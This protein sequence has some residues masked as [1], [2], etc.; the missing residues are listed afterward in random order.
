MNILEQFV[1]AV[2]NRGDLAHLVLFAWAIAASA[3]LAMTLRDLLAANRRFDEFV[4]ELSVFNRRQKGRVSDDI[5]KRAS[6]A[7]PKSRPET[8][9][10]P[11][12]QGRR[13][14]SRNAHLPRLRAPARKSRLCSRPGPRGKDRPTAH[15]AAVPRE[16][17]LLSEPLTAN[18]ETGVFEGYASLFGIPDLGKGRGCSGSFL[19]RLLRKRGT[20]PT[21]GCSGSMTRAIR[22][23]C[24]LSI[25]EDRRGLTGAGQ[26]QPRGRACARHPCAHARRGL[27]MACRSAFGSSGRGRNDRRACGGSKGSTCG[28]SPS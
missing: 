25:T 24:W 23:G 3:M 11:Q 20:S 16:I 22:S 27:S 4:R 18:D 26:A 8:G 28:K 15:A 1:D 5:D 10:N 21:S 9:S 17:K 6:S 2:I 19:A 14:R 7:R 12:T 13:S